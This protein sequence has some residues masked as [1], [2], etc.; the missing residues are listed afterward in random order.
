MAAGGDDYRIDYTLGE[1]II[2]FPDWERATPYY[3]RALAKVGKIEKPTLEDR[4]M[5]AKLLYR[6]GRFDDSVAAY[7]ALLRQFPR[8]RT[9]RDEFFDVLSEMGRYDR[10]WQLRGRRPEN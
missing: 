5:R 6:L 1:V 8:D 3:Q 7:E 2:T 4:M 9:L 10:A